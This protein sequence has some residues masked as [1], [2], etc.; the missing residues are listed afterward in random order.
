MNLLGTKIDLTKIQS[1][2]KAGEIN[3]YHASIEIMND[4][5]TLLERNTN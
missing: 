3:E 1:E 4:L 5:K 2:I